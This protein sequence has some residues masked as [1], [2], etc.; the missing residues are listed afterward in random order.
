[1][2]GLLAARCRIEAAVQVRT[3]FD[4]SEPDGEFGRSD[5]HNGYFVA[6]VQRS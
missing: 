3:T 1:M 4:D 2:R 5:W 6:V